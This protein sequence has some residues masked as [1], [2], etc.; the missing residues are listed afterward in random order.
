MQVTLQLLTEE[1]V[2]LH[3]LTGVC[4]LQV[5]TEVWVT[6]QVLTGVRLVWGGGGG[7]GR[8]VWLVVVLAE[9]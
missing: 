5:L 4:Y 1:G 3:V 9:A 8:S 6:L 7:G 2:T